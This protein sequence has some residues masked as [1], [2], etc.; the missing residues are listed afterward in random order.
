MNENQNQ[1]QETE[2]SEP[3]LAKPRNKMPLIA[4]AVLLVVVAAAAI[5]A[6]G[7]SHKQQVSAQEHLNPTSIAYTAEG[8]VG[9]VRNQETF[10]LY[11]NG[12]K[13]GNR[14]MINQ[15]MSGSIPYAGD[16][17]YVE[18]ANGDRVYIRM[19]VLS[20]TQ[21]NG[22]LCVRTADGKETE[23][24][25][26]VSGIACHSD[27]S[28]FYNKTVD[29]QQVQMCYQDGQITPVEEVLGE[30]ALSVTAI[31]KDG[32]LMQVAQLDE[33]RNTTASGYYYEG[34]LHLLDSN[35][36]VF[37]I[38]PI[39]KE[40]FVMQAP[41]NTGLVDLYRVKDLASAELEQVGTAV[42]E[43]VVYDD[44]SM[45]FV[46]DADIAANEHNPIGSIY[47][48]NHADAVVEKLADNAVAILESQMRSK[49]WMNENGR[50]LTTSE[51]SRDFSRDTQLWDGQVHYIDAQ[52][53]LCASSAQAATVGESGLQG[54]VI[55]EDFYQVDDYSLNDE[56]VFAT[57]AQN[58]LYWSR[59]ADLYRYHLGSMEQPDVIPLNE[60][61]AEKAQQDGAQIGYITSGSGDIIEESQQVLILKKFKEEN[62]VTLLEHVGEL[63]LAGLDN[64]G[65]T[66]YFISEDGSLYEKS[67]EN[68]SNPKLMDSGVLQ[69]Q[70][71]SDGLYYLLECKPQITVGASGEEEGEQEVSY[72][73]MLRPYGSSQSQLIAQ[74]INTISAIYIGQ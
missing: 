17:N 40:I 50:D 48:Y 63:N 13:G 8:K 59:G 64:D 4:A 19:E 51:I 44:G 74:D 65:R 28:V 30:D 42:T 39:G 29:G 72:N 60:S 25:E 16:K 9:I 43:A 55:S 38:A 66:I 15:I 52:G 35:Q 69:A 11:V 41:D 54:F 61:V 27:N 23:L 32:T 62:S 45:S 71:T 14:E 58:C 31:S 12:A 7:G 34:Q 70:A 67:V 24:D 18:L 37:Q 20:I 56:I 26:S 68:R 73:L 10:D 3:S 21:M 2:H 47:L 57:Y 46:G 49:G 1:N 5:W 36:T 6:F 22:K 33:N 53:N